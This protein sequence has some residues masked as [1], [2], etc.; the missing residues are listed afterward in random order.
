MCTFAL[1][2]VKILHWI[3]VREE[4][5][6]RNISDLLMLYI[7]IDWPNVTGAI[8]LSLQLCVMPVIK[9]DYVIYL[10][11]EGVAYGNVFLHLDINMQ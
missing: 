3:V 2:S 8:P 4:W 1:E 11:L 6:S 5:L 9:K 7:A 10:L